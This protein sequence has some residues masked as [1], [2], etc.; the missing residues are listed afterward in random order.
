MIKVEP[1]T[2]DA[3]KPYG[4]VI[5]ASGASDMTINRGRPVFSP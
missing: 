1:L 4:E 5:E 2:A 3:F